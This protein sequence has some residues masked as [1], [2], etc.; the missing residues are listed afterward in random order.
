MTVI[1]NKTQ[2][3]YEAEIQLKSVFC[4]VLVTKEDCTFWSRTGAQ[5]QNLEALGQAFKVKKQGIYL[6]ELYVNEATASLEKLATFCSPFRKNALTAPQKTILDD[7]AT[8]VVT[9]YLTVD[10]FTKGKSELPLGER[11]AIIRKSC[12]KVLKK[13]NF[14]LPATKL[15]KNEE[16]LREF[17][18]KCISKGNNG[19]NI[20]GTTLPYVCGHQ[21]FHYMQMVQGASHNLKCVGYEEGE[22]KLEGQ[23]ANLLFTYRDGEIKAPLGRTYS[24]KDSAKMLEVLKSDGKGK[25]KKAKKGKKIKTASS[26]LG[27]VWEVTGL[28]ENSKGVMKLPTVGKFTDSK[29]EF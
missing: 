2:F 24:A 19:I 25:K 18:A 15:C 16:E 17:S 14:A 23:V 3:P 28:E 8:L 1:K 12:K 11:R 20:K 21:N 5:M 7:K 9:D 6:A 29:A 13:I 26:P 22:G 4:A 10:E 27:Y